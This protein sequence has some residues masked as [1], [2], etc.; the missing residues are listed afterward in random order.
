[1]RDRMSKGR[2]E[3]TK[4]DKAD[5]G[6]MKD[7]NGDVGGGHKRVGG[8][9]GGWRAKAIS[10]STSMSRPGILSGRE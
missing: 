4:R 7:G 3:E 9:E 5:G 6:W 2:D 8:S 1:M 10:Q